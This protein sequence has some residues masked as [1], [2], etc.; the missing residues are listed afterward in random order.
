MMP[1]KRRASAIDNTETTAVARGDGE[2]TRSIRRRRVG[3]TAR[4]LDTGSDFRL[5]TP[6]AGHQQPDLLW[7]GATSRHGT[8]HPPVEEDSY[9]V[10]KREEFVEI[11]G[12]EEDS[13]AASPLV[14]QRLM[15]CLRG[16]DV[17]AAGGMNG[18]DEAGLT[19]E[20]AAEQQLLLVSTGKGAQ[21]RPA[22]GSLDIM[23]I[24]ETIGKSGDCFARQER[25]A[26]KWRPRITAQDGVFGEIHTAHQPG[27]QTVLRNVRDSSTGDLRRWPVG[28][29]LAGDTERPGSHRSQPGY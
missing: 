12:N 18:H 14:A 24:Q 3:E 10:R 28:Q 4:R 19:S 25:A 15:N 17:D 2:D 1:P 8:H 29:H 6:N 5:L 23:V 13:G 7:I 22:A 21:L 16:A 9:P 11:L 26:A 27:R 20:L